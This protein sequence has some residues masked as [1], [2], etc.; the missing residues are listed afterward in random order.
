M[1]AGF[2]THGSS[3]DS[4]ESLNSSLSNSAS[5]MSSPLPQFDSHKKHAAPAIPGNTQFS[6]VSGLCK[7]LFLY[8]DW[9]NSCHF[10]IHLKEFCCEWCD[11]II[12]QWSFLVYTSHEERIGNEGHVDRKIISLCIFYHYHAYNG[13][14]LNFSYLVT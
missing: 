11:Q 14:N 1:F 9:H 13:M 3:S 10:V 5:A 8:T 6:N 12:W 2:E 7:R 4:S